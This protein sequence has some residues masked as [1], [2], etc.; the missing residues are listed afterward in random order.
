LIASALELREWIGVQFTGEVP[1]NATR[2][3]FTYNW[4]AHWHVVWNVVPISPRAGAPQIEFKVLVER[5]SDAHI[6]Y[7][8]DVKN[9]TS[10]PVNIEARYALLGW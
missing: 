6:T 1:A 8:I 9:L 7:W 10:T 2:R 3:W 4:P 5:A